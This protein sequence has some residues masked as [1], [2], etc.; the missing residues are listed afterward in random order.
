MTEDEIGWHHR[1]DGHEFEWTLG[2]GDGHAMW[3][4]KSA[5]FRLCGNSQRFSGQHAGVLVTCPLSSFCLLCFCF[6]L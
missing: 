5:S 3:K 4:L 1:L 2:L 6:P